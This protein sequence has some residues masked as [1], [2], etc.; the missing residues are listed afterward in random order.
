MQLF[1]LRENKFSFYENYNSNIE[2]F[3]KIQ[4]ILNQL[5]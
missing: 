4:L 3:I 1:L 5:Y 2:T